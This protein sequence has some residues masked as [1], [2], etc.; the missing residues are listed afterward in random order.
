MKKCSKCKLDLDV[1]L[2]GKS[3]SSKDGLRSSC[4][5]C[6]KKYREENKEKNRE[7]TSQRWKEAYYKDKS[8]KKEKNKIYYD[9]NKIKVKQNSKDYYEQNKEKKLSYQK[10][11]QKNNKE[12]R[13]IYLCEKR[14]NDE[15][16][17]L[18]TNVRNLILNSFY[19][20]GYQKNSKTEDILGC[21]FEEFK[22][23]LESKFEEWMDWNNRGLYNGEM[24]YG[25]DI[26]HIIPLSEATTIDELMKLSHYT[27]LQPLCSK[28]NR[29]I[30][31]NQ[32]WQV[33]TL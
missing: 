6:Q 26:D 4:K 15:L 24:N 8:K 5:I 33:I 13:N 11:Y 19:N 16:F 25:W 31:R 14:K 23:Y 2:F 12:K 10:E 1:T 29:D 7:R 32:S 28:I 27:N 17:R 21:S 20:M 3:N 22:S 30:K 18:K 9:K